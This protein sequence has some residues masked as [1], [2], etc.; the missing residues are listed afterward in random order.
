MHPGRSD[1]ELMHQLT[2]VANQESHRL[3]VLD[4]KMRDAEL[5]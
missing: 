2:G 5:G 3:A 4:V 1:V